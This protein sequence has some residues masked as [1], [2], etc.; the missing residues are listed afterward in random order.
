[1]VKTQTMLNTTPNLG[2]SQDAMRHVEAILQTLL[3]DETLL[4]QKLRKFHWNVTGPQFHALHT[5]F[6]AQYDDIAETI[7]DIA[8]R[9]RAYGFFSHGT[10]AEFQAGTR[11]SERPGENPGAETMLQRIIEDHEA[12]VRYLRTDIRTAEGDIDDSGLADFLTAL[13]QKHQ[14]QAWMLRAFISGEG[15]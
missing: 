3:A 12:L 2:L 1:M 14:E 10:L 9:T 13:L 4:Y 5:Q 7:D 6:E 8:E 11:L 15:I